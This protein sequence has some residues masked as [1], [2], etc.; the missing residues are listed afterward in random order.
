MNDAC[1]TSQ[2]TMGALVAKILQLDRP[3]VQP[4]KLGAGTLVVA[5]PVVAPSSLEIE[6]Q[7]ERAARKGADLVEWR[8]DRAVGESPRVGKS[9]RDLHRVPTIFTIRTRAEGGDFI[10]EPDT[11]RQL[12]LGGAAW[13]DLVD[14]EVERPG[15]FDLVAAVQAQGAACILSNHVFDRPVDTVR[16][17]DMLGEME[18]LGADVAKVAWMVRKESDLEAILQT[19]R[20]AEKTLPIPASV[21]GMGSLGQASRIGGPARASAFTFAVAGEP[22]APGQL[23]I[24][25]VLAADEE[26]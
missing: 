23:S 18:E 25:A 20:W 4:L 16:L 2:R 12:T 10:F 26:A 17:R 14:V 3:G 15:S 1:C 9:F 22:S 8:F 5:C 24:E 19:Q 11:Y 7:W 6:E 21:I 13:A